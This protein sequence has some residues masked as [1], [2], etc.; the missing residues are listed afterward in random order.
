ME[1][2]HTKEIWLI[3]GRTI[4]SLHETGKFK[5]GEPELCNKFYFNIQPD[6]GR[7]ITDEQ[8]TEQAKKIHEA[9]NNYD[10]LKE[11]N[12]RL[13]ENLTRLIDRIEEGGFQLNFPSAYNRAKAALNPSTVKEDGNNEAKAL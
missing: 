9:I 4:Y 11:E 13:K 5:N 2:K 8:A 10:A 1:S 7:K 6:Y 3:E 12:E